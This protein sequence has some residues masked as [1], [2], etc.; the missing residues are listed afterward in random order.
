M[1]IPYDAAW[2]LWLR[3]TVVLGATALL[4]VMIW[5]YVRHLRRR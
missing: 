5:Q 1:I 3:I 2:P 4:G